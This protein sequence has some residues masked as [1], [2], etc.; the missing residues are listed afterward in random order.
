MRKALSVMF[1]VMMIIGGAVCMLTP[2]ITFLTLGYVVGLSIIFDGVSR[3]INWFEVHKEAKISGW[4][5]ASAILSLIFGF[6]LVGSEVLQLAVDAFIVYMAIIWMIA[7]GVMRIVHAMRVKKV[8]NLARNV[9]E[10]TVIGKH[11]WVAL[12]MGILMI[13]IGIVGLFMPGA[14]ASTIGVLVGI[15]IILSS[16]N[17]I[18][19]GTS[20]W[21]VL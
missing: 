5:L 15:G 16:I 11:W 13:V 14:V 7:I 19:F 4:V 21:M 1:G 2:G 18:Q 12:I 20:S 8:R 10:D 17:I 3:I 6:M 9:K